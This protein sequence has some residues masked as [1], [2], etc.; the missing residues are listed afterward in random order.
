M[1]ISL[2]ICLSISLFVC[3]SVRRLSVCLSVCLSICLS[4]PCASVS[5]V[6]QKSSATCPTCVYYSSRCLTVA[7]DAIFG[8]ARGHPFHRRSFHR[9]LAGETFA[10]RTDESTQLSPLSLFLP[11]N[12]E[13]GRR[14]DPCDRG[15]VFEYRCLVRAFAICTYSLP[16]N[17][18]S[19]ASPTPSIFEYTNSAF[20]NVALVAI[21]VW[22][23]G[24]PN[25]YIYI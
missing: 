1:P 2:S 7:S 13:G 4:V 5:A 19:C 22:R 25:E 6:T 17:P 20:A 15:S 23:I 3:L 12:R 24:C 8:D 10:N 16:V 9:E 18:I 14:C 11:P 21:P